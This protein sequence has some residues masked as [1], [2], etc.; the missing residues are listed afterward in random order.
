MSLAQMALLRRILAAGESTIDL[1]LAAM[2][3]NFETFLC[4]FPGI[5]GVATRP[6]ES[7]DAQWVDATGGGDVPPTDAA[8]LYL[9]GGGFVTG[10]ARSHRMLAARLSRASG[11][12]HCIL[13]YRLAPEHP[14]PAAL[15]DV[16]VAWRQL[17]ARGWSRLALAGDSSGAGLAVMAAARLR[18]AGAAPPTALAL[19]SPWVDYRGTASV[20]RQEDPMVRRPGLEMMAR[21]YLG[22]VA[23]ALASPRVLD[24]DGLPPM[25]IQVGGADAL[26]DDS[27]ALAESARAAG[28]A[29]ELKLWP[30]MIHGWQ[31]FA[32][33]LEEGGQAIEEAGRFLARSGSEG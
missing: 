2:R 31:L 1:P 26:L 10:S 6:A 4:R 20:D 9:H 21:L 22:G 25:L 23:E 12:P 13:E 14:F 11:L 32:A 5:D 27:L 18:D 33:R 7:L 29:V 3:A 8:V 30:G 16:L 19:F 24:L 28:V 17:R 15:D